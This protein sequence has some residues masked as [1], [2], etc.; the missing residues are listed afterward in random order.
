MNGGISEG[1]GRDP[2]DSN[3][4]G[5]CGDPGNDCKG[6]ISSDIGGVSL[7]ESSIPQIEEPRACSKQVE[8]GSEKKRRS[9]WEPRDNEEG[10]QDARRII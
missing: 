8:S 7:E 5:I 3:G 10:H 9:R 2:M 4:G 1:F 6:M